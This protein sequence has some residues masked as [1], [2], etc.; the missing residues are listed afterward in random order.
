LTVLHVAC[1][2]EGD[3]YLAHTATMLQSLL[4]NHRD[5]P[6]HVHF[7]PAPGVSRG[8]QS[9]LVEMVS[10][11]GAEISVLRVPDERLA[12]LPTKGFTRKATW[13]RIFLPELRPEL[14]RILYL[15]S[16]LLVLDSVVELFDSEL[17][18]NR[19]AA[20]T[21]VFQPNHLHRPAELGLAHPHDYFN[22]GVLLMDLERMRQGDCTSALISYGRRNAGRIDWRDQDVLNV[23]L[24]SRRLPL[25]PRWNVMNS[26]RWAHAG[27][28]FGRAHLDEACRDPAIRHFE[29][30]DDNK[31]WHYMCE[32]EMRELYAEYRRR[33]PWPRVRHAGVT[34]R[35]VLRRAR[36]RRAAAVP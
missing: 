11:E 6:V 19:V 36:R 2:A 32:R 15:D 28:V 9:R 29:G 21:N 5:V 3:G 25:H 31:P 17:L 16:D 26:F 30:P 33:T 7:M 24:G 27:D 14:D 34:P 18:G 10:G 35:N 4:A 12:G 8:R 20:V 13:Y 23:V 1:A 22:A